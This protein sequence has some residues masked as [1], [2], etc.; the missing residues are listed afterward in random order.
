MRKRIIEYY[1]K[2]YQAGGYISSSDLANQTMN[3]TTNY[4]NNLSKTS[5][6][7][8][9]SPTVKLPLMNNLSNPSG[10]SLLSGLSSGIS[11]NGNVIASVA[12][13]LSNGIANVL[14]GKTADVESNG[15]KAIGAVGS[16]LLQAGA[17][18][19][20]PFIIGAGALTT[21]F[22]AFNTHFGK[23]SKK[24]NT[25]DMNITGYSTD[26]SSMAGK[27][28]TWLGRSQAK[29][30]NAL[31]NVANT[32]NLEKADASYK[33]S[34]DYQAAQQAVSDDQIANYNDLY[35]LKDNTKIISSK[36]GGKFKSSF[37]D[38]KNVIPEGAL[39]ARKNG[40]SDEFD[41]TKKGIPV[42]S[43]D[44]NGDILQQ[45]EIEKNEIIFRKVVTE[46][47][48]LLKSKYEETGDDRFCILAG[49]ILTNEILNNTEDNTGLL[50][51]IK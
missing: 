50:N 9:T 8:I 3:N 24:Q 21:A 44:K 17:M 33:A 43:Q 27:K 28:T 7:G 13:P 25:S 26:I 20:N 14:G 19:G 10:K 1:V 32:N 12:S 22:D 11:K 18:T 4:F 39:H 29:K 2:S 37:Y 41:I 23:T 49:K 48:E 15:E 16:G 46:R 38:D 36:F 42:I 5:I 35:G 6:S 34:N 51:E 47:L 30:W 45:A 31:T 40:M